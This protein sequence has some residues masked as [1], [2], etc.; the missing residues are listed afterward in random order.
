M[1]LVDGRFVYSASDLNNFLECEQLSSLD[2]S[3]A[4]GERMRP[5][6]KDPM[7]LLIARKGEE[8]EQRYLERLLSNSGSG[9]AIVE[10]PPHATVS[11]L[12]SAQRQTIDAMQNGVPVIYQA[13]FF[14]GAFVGHADFL[15][16]V[17][18]PSAIGSWS[19]EV[20]D[21]K[22]ALHAKPYFLL[23]LCN[24]SE[25]V[26]RLQGRA[27]EYG[28]IVLGNGSERSFRLADYAAYYRHVKAS[29]LAAM[30]APD[31]YPL[32]RAHCA[33]CAWRPDCEARRDTDDHLSLVAG[34]R[35]DQIRKLQGAGIGTLAQL[36]QADAA[37]RPPKLAEPTFANLC[38]QAEQ[39]HFHREARR[40]G[41]E[42]HFYAFR[43]MRDE[44]SGFAKMPEPSDGDI[45]FDIEGD[46]IY[47]ADR[48]LEYLWGFYLPKE[49][50]YRA[51]WATD[52]S[53]EQAAFEG[54]VDFI[55]QRRAMF[56]NA[57][58]YHY[59][60]YETTAIRRLM[61]RFGS[62]EREVDDLLRQ[63]AFIDLF[64][65][66]RQALW[67]SQPSYS[68]KKVEAF[69]GQERSTQTRGGDDSIVMFEA[70]RATNDQALLEDIQKYNEDDCR[71][72]YRLRQ[73]LCDRRAEF[74]ASLASPVPW[75]PQPAT[76][77]ATPDER[78]SLAHALLDGLPTPD[79]LDELRQAD[80]SVRTRWLLGNLLQYHR[81]EN[82]PEWWT[83]FDRCA[84]P[85]DLQD[86]D[87]EAIGGM[88]LVEDAAPFKN[89]SGDHNLV[90][91]YDFPPQEHRLPRYPDDPRLQKRAGE[92]IGID[93]AR[94]RLQIKLSKAV[95]PGLLTALIPAKPLGYA[96]QQ[97][98]LDRLAQSYL[99]GELAAQGGATMQILLADR[100]RLG[101]S[102]PCVQPSSIAPHSVSEVIQAM[103]RSALFIQGPPGSGKTTYAAIAIVDL[104]QAGKRIGIAAQ[105]HK[106]VHN[107][108]R[109]VENVAL[110]R[111]FRFTGCHKE[112]STE[113]SAYEA[114]AEWPMV[115]SSAALESLLDDACKL[116]AAPVYSW[117][118]ERFV[119]R[120]DYVFADEAGQLSLADALIVSAAAENIVLVGDP[121]QL[122]QVCS[123]THPVGAALSV[124]Q[125]LL[126]P[127]ETIP[128]DR[129]IFLETSYRMHP[130]IC[131]FLSDAL[132]EGR[133]VSD[134]QTA[135][136]RIDS[137][138]LR[139]S[140][141]VFIPV[142]H[143]GNGRRSDEEAQR[144]VSEISLLLKGSAAIKDSPV[145][146]L[147]QSDI[148]VVSPYNVQRIRIRELLEM[149]GY[150]D[151]RVGTV[152]KFQGLEAAVMF[153][154][155]ATSSIQSLPRNAEFLFDRNRFNVAISRA[156][157]MSVLVCSPLLLESRCR[158][159]EQ[160]ALVNLLCAYAEAAA[161]P[162]RS[163][164]LNA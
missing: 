88:R 43:P 57:H 136:N 144:I 6:D 80:P 111:G 29:F 122:P 40:A 1:Q 153:Y 98:A 140:G 128:P 46:P 117:A 105:S 72:T 134:P 32:E 11:A 158:N 8:H 28:H 47:R 7:T 15:R 52:V 56:P 45:F 18:Q 103:N 78:G 110:R 146:A 22:L 41:R 120:C 142:T 149:A 33:I 94:G 129:G 74:N 55:V 61:G 5:D 135:N 38:R 131:T 26:A 70:W 37:R 20:V 115:S 102:R 76:D 130:A 96:K 82:K 139:G 143:E 49:N 36:A 125:H 156:Q 3:A 30:G 31:T 66:V 109:K 151:V 121:L 71:S 147:E 95:T 160:M 154:S 148:L 54:A 13:A 24:Y 17:E 157:C 59:A 163:V 93:G 86:N 81:R 60:P 75:R 161:K 112:S 53:A 12:E 152:D 79:S 116:A 27:P 63:G 159:P 35:F 16:R 118:D 127:D 137:P 114:L 106:A 4:L 34:I 101:A 62:R 9:V 132:Y 138:G 77:P 23:Q 64:H 10:R 68:I 145:R 83:Y 48:G 51:F 133:L 107:L 58:V 126:G 69:Y 50:E 87:D 92:I 155:M 100:P 84:S 123:G 113:G 164:L 39:Q 141:L 44:R 14:D 2:R 65:V 25:H 67:L 91:T 73:W 99:T 42:Q 150:T 89:S 85:E 108:L 90:Y 162:A 124:L 97:A 104:L 21:T 119:G 19:Y